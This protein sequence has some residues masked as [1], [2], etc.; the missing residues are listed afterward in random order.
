MR[1]ARA[2]P[3]SGFVAAAALV[4]A[5]DPVRW[6]IS[7]WRDPAYDSNGL[8]IFLAAAGLLAWSISSPLVEPARRQ[9]GLAFGL[10]ALSASVRLAGQVLAINT[11]GALCLVLDVYALG[12]LLGL[13]AR[14]R[15]LAP[16]WLAVVFAFSLPLE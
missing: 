11:I 6:L 4:L 3:A 15:S 12:L 14:V 9:H 10:I 1:L 5:V 8:L 13:S 2:R 7:T 16:A